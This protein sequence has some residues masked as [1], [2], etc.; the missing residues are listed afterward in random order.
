MQESLK[1]TS[2]VLQMDNSRDLNMD[3]IIAEVKTQYEDVAARSRN[4]TESWYKT[5]VKIIHDP[6]TSN[7]L[8]QTAVNVKLFEVK[9][10][11][12]LN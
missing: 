3:H 2:V 10:V 4:E 8:L 1:T 12:L 6:R 7:A 9:L 5:K 11:S